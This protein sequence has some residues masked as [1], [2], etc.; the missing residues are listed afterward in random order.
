LYAQHLNEVQ[1]VLL[2]MVVP[3]MDG[4]AI[5]RALRKLNPQC[6]IIATSGLLLHEIADE[7]VAQF[8]SKPFT[9]EKLLK[10]LAAVIRPT[11]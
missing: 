9:A 3:M 2:D 8:L 6:R 11:G 4:R 7:E 1:A 10:T 5:I